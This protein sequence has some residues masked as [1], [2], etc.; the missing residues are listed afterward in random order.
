MDGFDDLPDAERE[1]LF[2][3]FRVWQDSDAS[4]RSAAEVL[5]CHPNT[6]RHRLRRIEQT[7]RPISLA[8]KGCRRTLFG[9]RSAPTAHV[10]RWILV[11]TPMPEQR[12]IG[13]QR[14]RVRQEPKWIVA[15][16]KWIVRP[17]LHKQRLQRLQRSM[18][19]ASA[20]GALSLAAVV[21]Q[22]AIALCRR[23]Q[24]ATEPDQYE[25]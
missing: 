3:T 23:A 20:I 18:L 14:L 10:T 15:P 4:V 8:P 6:V 24:A 1:M 7:H 13:R 22:I 11:I 17:H 21:N 19:W 5:I 25:H 12:C 2:E 9:F 16:S